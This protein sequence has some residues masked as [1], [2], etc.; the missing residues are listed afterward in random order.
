MK[1]KRIL[2]GVMLIGF[3][4]LQG[5]AERNG[6][7]NIKEFKPNVEYCWPC[8]MYMQAFKAIN[9]VLDGVFPAIAANSLI[10]LQMAL[11][12]YILFKV[13]SL[14][15]SFSLP[16]MK[17]ELFSIEEDKP[18]GIVIVL[19]KAMLV[20]TLLVYPNY[21][22]EI[23]GGMIIQ[24]IG[25]GFLS[26]SETVLASPNEVGITNITYLSEQALKSIWDNLA[27][28][29][30]SFLGGISESRMFGPLALTVQQIVFKIFAAL[31]YGVGLGYQLFNVQGMS[32]FL[33]GALLVCGMVWLLIV[34]PLYFV[35]AFFRIGLIM[36]LMPLL[37]V[38]WVFSYPKGMIKKVVHMLL[39]GF[40]DILFNCI[41]ITFLV[42]T[43]RVYEHQ[44]LPQIFSAS[45]QT[46]E[47]GLRRESMTFGTNFV[48]LLLLVWSMLILSNHVQEFTK[49][50]F[51]E[52]ESSNIGAN[53]LNKAKYLAGL[54]VKGV[55][56]VATGGVGAVA[57]VFSKGKEKL[58]EAQNESS[59][60]NED[61]RS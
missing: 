21:I 30:S 60:Q 20:A 22:Y 27:S 35:D 43:F 10:V 33:A 52:S 38:G 23:F 58:S 41:Y 42:S 53:L 57:A 29:W 50:F 54:C 9:S 49:H 39:A 18:K 48:T 15:L 47:S 3:L 45:L 12:F 56:A 16:D 13:T 44:K 37:L 32:A 31:W 46:T 51:E 59:Q 24:P 25:Q 4:L 61:E 8:I 19:F 2:F 14:L 36:L 28:M 1:L 11:L 55:V 40:F 17:K 7:Y 26:L 5:C 34:I 6:H